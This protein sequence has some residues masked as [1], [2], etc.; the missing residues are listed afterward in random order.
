M[1]TVPPSRAHKI[2]ITSHSEQ[3]WVFTKHNKHT[4]LLNERGSHQIR[5]SNKNTQNIKQNNQ[6]IENSLLSRTPD[7]ISQ[8]KQDATQNT[9]QTGINGS[10]K[11]NTMTCAWSMAIKDQY[12]SK[13]G[14]IPQESGPSNSNR[15]KK[16][17]ICFLLRNLDHILTQ[18]KITRAKIEIQIDNMQA[19]KYSSLPV[20]GTGPYK[21]LIDDYDVISNIDYYQKRIENTHQSKIKYSHIYSHLN[22]NPKENT[23]L[24]PKEKYTSI[25]H[26]KNH[27]KKPK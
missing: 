18:H 10:V 15:A 6:H 7:Q 23:Y 12:P 22:K 20:E 9:L 19:L 25:T 1:P 27:S 2:T 16:A 17:G 4:I 5:T 26:T 8:I 13:G 3:S 24:A 21:L 11:E 14:T